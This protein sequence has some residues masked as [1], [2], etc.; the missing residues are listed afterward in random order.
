MSSDLAKHRPVLDDRFKELFNE[1]IN[2]FAGG[3]F[4]KVLNEQSSTSNMVKAR[5]WSDFTKEFCARDG[6]PWTKMQL[7]SYRK[8]VSFDTQKRSNDSLYINRA[9]NRAYKTGGGLPGPE[10]EQTD[11]DEMEFENPL[12]LPGMVPIRNKNTA[13]TTGNG[14]IVRYNYY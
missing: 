11:G 10:P 5:L 2:T 4:K 12:D 7:Q 1:M 6:R 14:N 8:R 3:N 9:R 13:T